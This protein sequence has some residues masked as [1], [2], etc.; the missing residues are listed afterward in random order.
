[1][2]G[3]VTIAG[4][5]LITGWQEGRKE[6]AGTDTDDQEWINVADVNDIED[7]YGKVVTLAGRERIAVLKYDGKVSAVSNV[8][9]HQHG[10]LGEGKVV[11]GCLTCPWHGYQCL[12]YNGQSPPPFTEK[13]PTYR[14]SVEGSRILV[15]PQPLPPGMAV[16]PA[17]IEATTPPEPNHE[18]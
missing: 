9:A 14:V 8:C 13:I 10:P 4:L 7:G 17:T 12:P 3:F 2:L 18:A 16:E 5:H 1:M 15:N 6:A 11:D